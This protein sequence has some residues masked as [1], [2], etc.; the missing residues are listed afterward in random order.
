MTSSAATFKTDPFFNL[1]DKWIETA[2]DELTHYFDMGDGTPLLMMHGSGIGTGAA[3]TWWRNMPHLSQT[4]RTIAF[5]FIGYGE[6]V[7][8]PD[9]TYG[10]RQWGEHTLRLMDALAIDKAWLVGSSLGGWVAMQLAID[11][12]ERILG[13]ISIG[14]GGAKKAKSNQQTPSTNSVVSASYPLTRPP[15]SEQRIRQNLEKNIKN[16]H[17]ICDTLIQ[18]RYQAALKES[19]TGLRPTLYDAREYDRE[20]LPLDMDALSQLSI[21]VLLVHGTEDLVVPVS[22]SL[23]LLDIIPTADAYLYGQ[24]G[25]W[26][27]IGK[28]EHFNALVSGYIATHSKN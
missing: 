17:L 20:N 15:L 3:M 22:R 13:V 4:M 16:D 18:L 2:P 28:A 6:S 8:A 10:I 19:Q 23:M 9:T 7:S 21:P 11:Y 14:T 1:E 27:H 24:S 25:H 5:D 26:P 12:P